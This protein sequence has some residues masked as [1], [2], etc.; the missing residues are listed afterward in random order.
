[1]VVCIENNLNVQMIN[2]SKPIILCHKGF[3]I[4]HLTYISEL[5]KV[6]HIVTQLDTC[7]MTCN[8]TIF[9]RGGRGGAHTLQFVLW[10]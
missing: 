2:I 3:Y 7:V 10:S 1:M 9:S 6:I 5:N 8:T 4:L